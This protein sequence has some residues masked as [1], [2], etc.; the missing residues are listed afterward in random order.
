MFR[1]VIPISQNFTVESF[2][3]TRFGSLR[4]RPDPENL[5]RLQKSIQEN[6]Q[7]TSIWNY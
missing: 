2:A 6:S 5:R 4:K 7:P 3:Q 1:Y